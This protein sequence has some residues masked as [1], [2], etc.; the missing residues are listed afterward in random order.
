MRLAALVL[1]DAA[2]AAG[3]RGDADAQGGNEGRGQHA[4]EH[5]KTVTHANPPVMTR[6]LLWRSPSGLPSGRWQA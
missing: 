3:L 4:A 2:D 5:M 1:D 6:G